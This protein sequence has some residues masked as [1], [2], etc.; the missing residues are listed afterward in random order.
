MSGSVLCCTK[1]PS[2]FSLLMFDFGT[3][4][5]A[6]FVFSNYCLISPICTCNFSTV[7]YE[8][9]VYI[10]W[11]RDI[12]AY[13]HVSYNIEAKIALSQLRKPVSQFLSVTLYFKTLKDVFFTTRA[14]FAMKCFICSINEKWRVVRK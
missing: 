8:F 14:S 7:S 3:T 12:F 4:W 1:I 11:I 13:L 2:R 5:F 9:C 10:T 6:K